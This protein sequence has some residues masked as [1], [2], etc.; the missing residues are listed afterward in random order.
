M[1]VGVFQ[2][3]IWE[4]LVTDAAHPWFLRPFN[5]P[6]VLAFFGSLVTLWSS[7]GRFGGCGLLG[8]CQWWMQHIQVFWGRLVR[9]DEFLQNCAGL[10][11]YRCIYSW[12]TRVDIFFRVDCFIDVFIPG[13]CGLAVF[14][15]TFARLC[16]FTYLQMHSFLEYEGWRCFS[17]GHLQDCG[18]LLLYRCIYSW[19]M[20][21]G[22]VFGW[23]F[24][25]LCV[26]TSL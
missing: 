12:T 11:F 4:M 5:L 1:W 2:M 22:T 10:L 16:G 6:T 8:R 15:W 20:R 26:L 3:N 21:V 13:I 19:N 24:A 18:C 25:G 7:A 9:P 17:N 23:T 14:R